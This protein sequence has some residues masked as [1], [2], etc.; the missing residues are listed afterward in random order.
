MGIDGLAG[1]VDGARGEVNDT[2]IFWGTERPGI[3]ECG[4]AIHQ[5]GLHLLWVRCKIRQCGGSGGG[6]SCDR[7]IRAALYGGDGGTGF[8]FPRRGGDGRW[9]A[10]GTDTDADADAADADAD[11]DADAAS[12]DTASWGFCGCHS[13]CQIF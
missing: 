13:Y 8:E 2:R 12:A 11:A 7:D 9:I 5:R 3:C 10:T 6:V 1:A 4:D